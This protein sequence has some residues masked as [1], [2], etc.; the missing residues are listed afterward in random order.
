MYFTYFVQI[1]SL[2]FWNIWRVLKWLSAA[3]RAAIV[4]PTSIRIVLYNIMPKGP[5]GPPSHSSDRCLCTPA[6]NKSS[7]TT[8][9]LDRQ[10]NIA[11][12]INRPGWFKRWILGLVSGKYSFRITAGTPCV[13][14]VFRNIPSTINQIPEELP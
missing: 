3:W 1:W 11:A 6:G 8:T 4:F 12:C 7:S 13:T 9:S 14:N 5:C 2:Y 10:P